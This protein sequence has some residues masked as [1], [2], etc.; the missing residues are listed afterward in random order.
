MKIAVPLVEG[1]LSM[2]FGHCDQFAVMDMDEK[3]TVTNRE[4][5]T[6]PPHEPGVLPAWLHSF[7]VTHIIAGGMGSR[8]QNLFASN[9]I[10]VIIGAPSKTPEE[11]ASMCVAGTLVSGDNVCDH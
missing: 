6:P 7:D 11:L 3:G 10:T 8:A 5:M 1:N 9:G 2:H 4:D